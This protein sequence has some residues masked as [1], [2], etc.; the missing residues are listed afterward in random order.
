LLERIEPKAVG[1][2]SLGSADEL[3][4]GESSESFEPPAE[5]V[6]GDEVGEMLP[7]LI[8]APVMEALDSRVPD[9]PAHPL[10]LAVGPRTLVVRCSMSFMA[11]EYSKAWAKKCSPLAMAS[12]ITAKRKVQWKAPSRWRCVRLLIP[13]PKSRRIVFVLVLPI[14]LCEIAMTRKTAD[15]PHRQRGGRITGRAYIAETIV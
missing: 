8:M 15:N 12:L 11:Q 7:K 6:S 2:R 9:G 10:D 14:A 3:V 1:L 5:V 13:T 4:T